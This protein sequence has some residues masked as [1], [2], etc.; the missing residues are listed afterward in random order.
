MNNMISPYVFPGISFT[1]KTVEEKACKIFHIPFD[2]LWMKTRKRDYV[3]ARWFVSNFLISYNNC[4]QSSIAHSH[5]FKPC[6]M[7]YAVKQLNS[8]LG[9]DKDLREKYKKFE[10]ELLL[11]KWKK[12][13]GCKE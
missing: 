5:S 10:N 6:T 7:N 11:N 13:E 12:D 2:N 1:K 3:Q 4:S 8:L 9:V